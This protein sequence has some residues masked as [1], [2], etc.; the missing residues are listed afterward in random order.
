MSALIDT[1]V[2]C[3]YWPFRALTT[4][5]PKA[6]KALLEPLG[7]TQ[8]WVASSE[9]ILYP[10]PMQGN[11]PLFEAIQGD[12]FF[13]PVAIIDVTL[14]TWERDAR[15]CVERWG[16]GALK[17]V[18]NYQS[19]DLGYPRLADLL[20]LAQALNVP[21]CIQVRMMDERAHHPLM[22]VPGVSCEEI[23][24]LAARVPDARVLVCGAYHR[25]LAALRNSPSVWAEISMVESERPLRGAIDALGEER[26]V[27]GSHAPF[28]YPTAAL[29]KVSVDPVDVS[30]E[31]VEA[32]RYRNAE[33]LLRR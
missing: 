22:K 3:G 4:R 9:A 21:V 12:P 11:A 27:F 25:E 30:A 10:D 14:A 16:C 23:A 15:A 19:C 31:V 32:V 2:F 6:L 26:V 1:S 20:S 33:G 18:P 7:V 17:T 28:L 24:G 13:I 29:A 8:A 5:T